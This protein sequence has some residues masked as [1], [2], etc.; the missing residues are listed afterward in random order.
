M[1][2]REIWSLSENYALPTAVGFYDYG[3]FPMKHPNYI[4]MIDTIPEGGY[5]VVFCVGYRQNTR[6]GAAD[7]KFQD[8]GTIM[9]IGHDPSMLGSTFAVDLDV[10][11]NVRNTLTAING[12]WKPDHANLQHI[13]KRKQALIAQSKAQGGRPG[14]HSRK[15]CHRHANSSGISG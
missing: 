4:G 5:D 12:Q 11:G 1:L 15:P 14:K 6:A 9:A 7:E 10:L 8:A 2:G 3:A 13:Q